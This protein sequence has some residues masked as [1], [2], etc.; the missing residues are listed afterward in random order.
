MRGCVLVK[1]LLVVAAVT[2]AFAALPL[3]PKTLQKPEAANG[4]TAATISVAVGW[5]CASAKRPRLQRGKLLQH[6][7]LD[8]LLLITC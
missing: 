5:Q 7:D 1:A 4:A 6:D 8:M 2:A 3:L